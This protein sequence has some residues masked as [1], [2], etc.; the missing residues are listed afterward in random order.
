MPTDVRALQ[1]KHTV[2]N[3]LKVDLK[4]HQV[5][6]KHLDTSNMI[7]DPLKERTELEQEGFVPLK[8]Y[9]NVKAKQPV[10]T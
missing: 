2:D 3:A 7:K 8:S 10:F 5:S 4:E 6:V 1:S 9:S